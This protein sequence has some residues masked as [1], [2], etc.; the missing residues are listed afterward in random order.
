MMRQS[1]CGGHYPWGTF[2]W[3][4]AWADGSPEWKANPGIRREV[5]YKVRSSHPISCRPVWSPHQTPALHPG[6]VSQMDTTKV[7]TTK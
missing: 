7:R 4:G 3:K 6:P 1:I 2:E 5:D